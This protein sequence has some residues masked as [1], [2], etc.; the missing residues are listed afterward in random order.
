MSLG[1]LAILSSPEKVINTLGVWFAA[2][3]LYASSLGNDLYHRHALLEA[4]VKESVRELTALCLELGVYV[5]TDDGEGVPT[6]TVAVETIDTPDAFISRYYPL[7]DGSRAMGFIS[8]LP[9]ATMCKCWRS[10][11]ESCNIGTYVA[12]PIVLITF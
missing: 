3:L 7:L 9:L 12:M 1:D 8:R 10:L 6:D 2:L 5:T 11:V 4:D